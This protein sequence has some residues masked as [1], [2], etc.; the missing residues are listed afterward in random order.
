M[1]INDQMQKVR[2]EFKA[3]L[4]NQFTD[5]GTVNQIRIKY[6]GRK[7][8]VANL[9]IQMGKVGS[10]KRPKMG[11]ILNKLKSEITLEIDKLETLFLKYIG[12]SSL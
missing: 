3:D 6:L 9:F 5:N 11:K 1:S 2:S 7:G 12:Q 10:D 4:E 8:L